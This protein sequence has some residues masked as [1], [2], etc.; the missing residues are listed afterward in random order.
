MFAQRVA[1]RLQLPCGGVRPQLESVACGLQRDRS[2]HLDWRLQGG[3]REGG[4]CAGQPRAGVFQP[5]LGGEAQLQAQQR[6]PATVVRHARDAAVRQRDQSSLRVADAGD[7]HADRLHHA[8]NAVD[9]YLVANG[10]L[11]FHEDEKAVQH[12]AHDLL[13]AQ[14]DCQSRDA[15]RRQHRRKV[16][17]QRAQDA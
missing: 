17:P 9:G 13:R 16:H 2:A 8:A 4:A 3:V 11:V 7:T 15:R 1:Q 12:I 5:V 10:K 14:A 6:A